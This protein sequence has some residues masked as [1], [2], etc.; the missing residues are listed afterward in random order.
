MHH[1]HIATKTEMLLLL[2]NRNDQQLLVFILIVTFLFS[3]FA[4]SIKNPMANLN[5]RPPHRATFCRRFSMAMWSHKS[6]SACW[7]SV[8]VRWASLAGVC[9]WIRCLHL[10]CRLP[11]AKVASFGCALYASSKVWARDQLYHVHMPCWPNGYRPLNDHAWVLLSTQVCYI[12][13]H[14][15]NKNNYVGNSRGIFVFLSLSLSIEQVH[16]LEP[17]FRCRCLDFYR[18]MALTAAG[19]PFFMCSVLLVSFGRWPSYSSFMKS[20]HHIHALMKKKRN[21]LWAHCGEPP[22][23]L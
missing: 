5:G 7:P 13:Q 23:Y 2:L 20:Q 21:I 11:L 16:N 6:P 4:Y 12:F 19:H 17:L 10:L 8:T 15:H 9:C 3:F 18:S 14:L 1:L 22:L